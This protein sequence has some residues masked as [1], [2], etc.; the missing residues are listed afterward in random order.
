[1]NP[2]AFARASLCAAVVLAA[3]PASAD[4]I[5]H[6]IPFQS[7]LLTATGP[8][9]QTSLSVPRFDPNL[10]HLEAVSVALAAT[11]TGSLAVENTSGNATSSNT[12]VRAHVTASSP[13]GLVYTTPWFLDL[14][15]APVLA[16]FDGVL[17]SAG[18]SGATANFVGLAGTPGANTQT[19]ASSVVEFLGP[20]GA[21][22]TT[23]IALTV[24]RYMQTLP[25]SLTLVSAS[26]LVAEGAVTLTYHY[27]TATTRICS[28]DPQLGWGVCPCG[29]GGGASCGNSVN[30]L[31]ASLHLSGTPSIA[32]DTVA[33]QTFGLPNSSAIFLQGDALTTQTAFGDGIRCV[34][35]NLIRLGTATIQGGQAGYPGPG[36]LLVSVRGQVVAPCTRYYQTYYR[37]AAAYCTPATANLSDGLAVHWT[38]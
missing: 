35:G 10:G 2:L 6:T 26:E 11:M 9:W 18:T 31:G 27:T 4:E 34:D 8:T 38:L 24:G 36:Q 19:V 3:R 12:H 20:A 7:P 16:P 23:A 29:W 17:D 1:M 5:T 30:T 15:S 28:G 21:P 14:F 13:A 32:S 33:F 22:G 25:L 37:N